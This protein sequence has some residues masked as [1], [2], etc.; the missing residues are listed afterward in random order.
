MKKKPSKSLAIRKADQAFSQYIR[1]KN[2]VDSIAVCV[3]CGIAKPWKEMQAGHFVSRSKHA[4]RY[5]E[6]N[7]HV[8]CY[9]CNVPLKGNYPS[10]ALF[11]QK[12]Y[13]NNILESLLAESQVIRKWSVV[14]LEELT[15][16]WKG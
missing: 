13:G 3:T 1:Q 14:E 8:Q 6:R 16:K 15:A 5:D 12:K 11:L 2:A 4:L 10:Y 9:R 7:V